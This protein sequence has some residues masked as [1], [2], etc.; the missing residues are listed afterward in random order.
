MGSGGYKRGSPYPLYLRQ[1]IPGF[2]GEN[3]GQV[4]PT[5]RRT[6]PVSPKRIFEL[7][8]QLH[9]DRRSVVRLGE[10]ADRSGL[11]DVV[12]RQI[13]RNRGDVGVA[14]RLLAAEK[15]ST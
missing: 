5:E 12:F 15:F 14:D 9:R 10:H 6:L 2:K 11:Q 1:S 3:P 13:G 7:T 4:V 8:D